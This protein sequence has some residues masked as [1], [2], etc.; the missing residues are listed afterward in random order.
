MGSLISIL[1]PGRS[2]APPVQIIRSSANPDA[3]SPPPP[4]ANVG[5]TEAEQEAQRVEDTLRR[6]RGQSSTILTSYRGVLT[7]DE[8]RPAR[9]TLLGE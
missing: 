7:P 4:P 8:V 5:P 2:K 1:A 3:G 6:A 9:K